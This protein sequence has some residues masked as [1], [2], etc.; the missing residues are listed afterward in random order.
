VSGGGV[1]RRELIAGGLTAG[2]AG[3]LGGADPSAAQPR[4]RRV[5]HPKVYDVAVVGAGLAGLSAA[6]SVR[7]AG[8]SV[9]VLEAR[10]RVG[11]R[12]FDHPLAPG[13]VAELGG[14]WAGPGQDVVLG[15]AKELGVAIFD[16]YSDGNGVYYNAQGDLQTYNGDIPPA[17][18]VSLVELEAAMSRITRTPQV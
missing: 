12:N 13:K 8:R 6:T 9:V 17:S 2:A 11:G 14:E 15:L 4:R 16:A 7:A 18:P 5:P 10:R 3:V 1:R